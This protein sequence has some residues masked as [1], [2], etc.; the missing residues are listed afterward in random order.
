VNLHAGLPMGN[1]ALD[2]E[3]DFWDNLIVEEQFIKGPGNMIRS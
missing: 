3:D 2:R 1:I